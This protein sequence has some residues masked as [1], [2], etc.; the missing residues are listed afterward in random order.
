[1]EQ[2]VVKLH[3]TTNPK[4]RKWVY[5][6]GDKVTEKALFADKMSKEDALALTKKYEDFGAQIEKYEKQ[7]VLVEHIEFKDGKTVTV[8]SEIAKL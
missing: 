8:S 5:L 2:F 3:S 7:S 6:V 1:M 4:A